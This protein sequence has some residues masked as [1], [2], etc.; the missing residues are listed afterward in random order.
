PPTPALLQPTM[1]IYFHDESTPNLPPVVA[2]GYPFER[3]LDA[4]KRAGIDLEGA[5][6][7]E[8]ECATCHVLLDPSAPVPPPSEDELDALDAYAVPPATDRTAMSSVISWFSRAIGAQTGSDDDD[9]PSG[10]QASAT[11]KTPV[12]GGSDAVP[13][14]SGDAST[15]VARALPIDVEVVEG[16]KPEKFS[17]ESSKNCLGV[18]SGLYQNLVLIAA[19]FTNTNE[20]GPFA[21]PGSSQAPASETLNP[22]FGA[23]VEYSHS[24]TVSASEYRSQSVAGPVDGSNRGNGFFDEDTPYSAVAVLDNVPI[25]E[26]KLSGTALSSIPGRNVSATGSTD[27]K[28]KA[29]A[30]ATGRRPSTS[31]QTRASQLSSKLA[32]AGLG[33]SPVPPSEATVI[34]TGTELPDAP[35]ILPDT[36]SNFD[37]GTPARVFSSTSNYSAASSG[38]MHSRSHSP[39]KRKH[40]KK[41]TEQELQEIREKPYSNTS[42]IIHTA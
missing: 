3:L 33:S 18:E 2:T 15:P 12:L 19:T 30:D 8:M 36:S 6:G 25:I 35:N 13:T 1:Q 10:V 28:G 40:R 39:R 14:P 16:R 11:V 27:T 5:C 20:E 42:R 23:G 32:S 17:S 29:P 37:D 21:V 34:Q 24:R 22:F 38:S 26:T 41:H 9:P 7:G 31:S 4:A